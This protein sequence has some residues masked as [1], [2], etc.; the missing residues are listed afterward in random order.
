MRALFIATVTPAFG[1]VALL[2]LRLVVAFLVKRLEQRQAPRRFT[3]R[4]F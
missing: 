2:V 3:G 1:I 4:L